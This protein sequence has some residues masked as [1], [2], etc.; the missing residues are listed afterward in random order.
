MSTNGHGGKPGDGHGTGGR[1]IGRDAMARPLPKRFYTVA[2]AASTSHKRW[3][4]ELD[5]RP[6]R[7]PAKRE[8][9]HPLEA[10]IQAIA[11]EWGAQGAV[12]DPA[13]MPLTRLVNSAIDGVAGREGEV[14]ADIAR[15]ATSDLVCYRA[16][17]PAELVAR[18]SALWDPV[19]AWARSRHGLV[20]TRQT[21]LMPVQQPPSVTDRMLAALVGADA[22]RLAA[23]HVM[24]TLTGSA[25]LSLAIADKQLTAHAAWEAAHVDEDWQITQWGEDAEAQARRQAR[26]RDM[27]AADRLLALLDG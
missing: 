19:H 11:E 4:L 10:V 18:Q 21:G 2:A 15:Y 5:G 9:A 23:L 24:T 14:A 13:S 6:A 17:R 16:D 26:W 1:K 12:I 22:F 7:T 25:I 3:R 27:A 8:F 20:L